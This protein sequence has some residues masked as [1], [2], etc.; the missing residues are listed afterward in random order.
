MCGF[1]SELQNSIAT[2]HQT[3]N[4]NPRRAETKSPPPMYAYA[5]SQ[6]I[7]YLP[8]HAAAFADM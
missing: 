8:I 5:F 3:Y 7:V 4:A 6:F 1:P 2:T